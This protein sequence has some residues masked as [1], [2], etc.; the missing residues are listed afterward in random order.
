MPNT[1][2]QGFPYPA[3]S[4]AAN[5][6]V[7]FQNLA[8]AIEKRVVMVFADAAAR[9]AAVT[10][11][12]AG[13]LSFLTST[14]AFEWYTGTAWVALRA[15]TNSTF[16]QTVAGSGNFVKPTGPAARL[17]IVELW[18][19][20]AAGGGAQGVSGQTAEGGGGG[21]GAYV[22]RVYADSELAASEPF[23]VG[24]GGT[25]VTNGNGNGGGNS[26]FK[27]LVAGGGSGGTSMNS[28]TIDA[29]AQHGAGGAAS[30]GHLNINGGDGC[31]GRRIGSSCILG[32]RGGA[33]PLGGPEVAFPTFVAANGAPGISPGGGGSGAF[34]GA[35]NTAGGP[36]AAGKLLV[37]SIY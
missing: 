29:G 19:A 21:A 15:L 1:P 13:M 20:G 24:A 10:A 17:H 4:D 22:R 36:G 30:G 25:G 31:K 28:G 9:T 26:T 37:T 12:T 23:T 16:T 2:I 14:G 5:G 7:A 8:Q 11:P 3:L 18:G 27:G 33:S 34:A 35:A 6:P 32:N